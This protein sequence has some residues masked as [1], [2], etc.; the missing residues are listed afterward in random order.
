MEVEECTQCLIHS[1]H[2]INTETLP[3]EP[4]TIPSHSFPS[5]TTPP[6]CPMEF[7]VPEMDDNITTTNSHILNT[8]SNWKRTRKRRGTK[9]NGSGIFSVDLSSFISK[10][11][12]SKSDDAAIIDSGTTSH[13]CRNRSKF[14]KI[15][16]NQIVNI[17]GVSG[18]TKGKRGILK[19]NSLGQH[20]PAIF[21]PA[22]PVEILLSTRG[23]KRDLWE[24]H[25]TIDDGDFIVNKGS[26]ALISMSTETDLP[27]IPLEFDNSKAYV[28]YPNNV[29]QSFHK[30]SLNAPNKIPLFP[31][32]LSKVLKISKNKK[33]KP[34]DPTSKTSKLVEHWRMCH[35]SE[36]N[37]SIKCTECLECKGVHSGHTGERNEKF[38]TP[39]PLL[40]FATDF[41]GKVKPTSYHNKSWS[42]L[43]VCDRCGFAAV[44]TLA[45]KS[46]APQALE[47]FVKE[48]R[49][50]CGVKW[51]DNKTESGKLIFA[52]IRSDNEP[53]LR[54]PAWESV[55]QKYN[56]TETHSVPYHPAMNGKIERLVATIKS[57][58]RTTCH[59]VDPR[60]WDFAVEHIVK[61]WNLRNSKAATKCSPD[62]TD[63]CPEKIVR[64]LNPNPILNKDVQNKKK[65][66]RRFGC[67]V[68][69][70]PHVPPKDKIEEKNKA[71]KPVRRKGIHLGFSEKNSAWKVGVV[72]NGKLSVYESISVTF[73]EDILVRNISELEKP[74]PPIFERLLDKANASV[75]KNPTAGSARAGAGEGDRYGLEGLDESRWVEPALREDRLL[76][77]GGTEIDFAAP[78]DES[79]I[80]DPMELDLGSPSEAKKPDD[81]VKE[82]KS[83]ADSGMP[84]PDCEDKIIFGPESVK[85]GRGRPKGSKNKKPRKD[86]KLKN[87]TDVHLQNSMMGLLAEVRSEEEDEFAHLA[88]DPTEEELIEAEVFLAFQPSK[89]GDS[90]KPKDAFHPDNP[91]RPKW[92]E[93]KVLEQVRLEAYKTWRKLTPEEEQQW[94]EGKIQAVPCALLL[95]RKRCGRHKARLVVLGNRWK[96]NS[97]DNTV[98]ASVVSQT[99]NRATMV[100]CAKLG[101]VPGPFDIG[102]A[103]VRASMGSIKVCIRLPRS[104]REENQEDDGK[105]ML[106]K[107]LYG[108]P[109]SPRLWAKTLAHDLE[110]LGWQECKMEPGVWLL[111]EET[112]EKKILAYLTVYVDDC[113]LA[114]KTK[115]IMKEQMDRIHK[116]HPLSPIKTETTEDGTMK[117][118]LCGADIEYN[119]EKKKLRIHMTN[120]VHKLLKR[121]DMSNAKPKNHPAFPE[122]N[123]Y[124]KGCN[125]SIFPY[126][127]CVGALQWLATTARPDVAHATNMLARASAMPVTNNM[128]KCCREVMRYLV[129]TPDL[130]LEYSPELEEEFTRKYDE[131]EEHPDNKG[132]V[133]SSQ[134]TH[135]VH[136]YSDASFGVTYREM[137]SITGIVVYLHGVPVAWRS[138]VQTVFASSTTESEW[139]AA[140]DALELTESVSSLHNFLCARKPDPT[141]EPPLFCDNRGAVISGRKGLQGSEE[142]P[143]R[144]RHVALR[145]IRVLEASKRLWFI[146]TAAQR[147][148]GLTKSTN[149]TALKLIFQNYPQPQIP[150]EAEFDDEWEKEDLSCFATDLIIRRQYQYQ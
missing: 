37:N 105:R 129:A 69:F 18:R 114:G 39:S 98:Y 130:G 54:S 109:I 93:G 73:L 22:L 63:A 140:S 143:R 20:L 46:E 57:A 12:S 89:P 150:D 27:T 62:G 56:I 87:K 36:N 124:T 38:E 148:D 67:L 106:Q 1:A 86:R 25:F 123:L 145:F 110:K 133:Q 16:N 127:E 120:Y 32:R 35:L 2:C 84:P 147:A 68:Y 144:T 74:D 85:R 94:R 10:L 17:N 52:G 142:I 118:D 47:E 135:P 139:I 8:P 61:V 90:V 122:Q 21:L 4:R 42:M 125:P 117:F 40:L 48:I 141:Q 34:V 107:A 19:E 15:F 134:K 126:R 50:R 41:F 104:F 72:R 11:N 115:K 137:R 80:D 92:V 102:N 29:P 136:T 53:V 5:E 65:Y 97:E 116:I 149:P 108:L 91:E 112:G 45:A 113:V 31:K 79:Q 33:S 132:I 96:P 66:L 121:F 9:N 26:G 81:A 77:V 76:H 103:F 14:E 83:K 13:I 43:F 60:V 75:E 82:E 64:D 101:F 111:R 95:N 131:I 59:N 49:A 51:G 70:K 23:L 71:L 100:H 138:R 28:V 30:D 44:K 146:P 7:D 119:P 99:A 58:L 88:M 24:T 6:N 3:A 128:A 78:E 55:C